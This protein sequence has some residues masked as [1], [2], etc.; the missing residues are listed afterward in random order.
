[1][2]DKKECKCGGN[3]ECD[4]NCKCHEED[5]EDEE[6][7]DKEDEVED[8]SSKTLGEILSKYEDDEDNK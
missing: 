4:G 8:E 7:E 2:E 5:D 1:M 3:C 6:V